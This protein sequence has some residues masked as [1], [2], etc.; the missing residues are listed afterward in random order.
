MYPILGKIGPLTIYSFGVMMA[1]GFYLGT[2]MAVREYERRGGDGD[3]LWSVLLWT[4]LA[5]VASARVLSIFNDIPGFFADPL[6]AFSG[7]G[8]VWYGGF[9]GG[10]VTAWF[11]T[12]RHKMA[13]SV[14]AECASLGL[15]LGQAIGRL[16]CHVA[17]DGDWGVPT[18]LPWGL[19][20][21][22]AIVGWPHPEGVY[23]H[24]T[25]LY[26]F[27]A[28]ML[29]FAVLMKVRH[30]NPPVGTM[31]GIYLVGNAFFRFVVEFWRINPKWI[32]GLTQAQLIAVG[33]FVA[34]VVLLARARGAAGGAARVAR[35]AAL[36]VALV[37]TVVGAGGCNP[38]DRGIAID[39]PAPGFVLATSDGA[40][41]KLDGWRG[42][43]VL[44]N[45]WAT[46][47]PPCVA[48]WPLLNAVQTR[49]ADRGLVV[50]AVAGDEN[51]EDVRAFLAEN[52][53]QF[54]VLLDPD[55]AVGTRYGITGYPETF[56][57]D[58][59]GVVRGKYIGPVPAEGDQP[60]AEFTELVERLVAS[61]P[62]NL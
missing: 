29:V 53:A 52:P 47:C 23:V 49:F 46:W 62:P 12:R 39:Q 25:P 32:F 56:L 16:G 8:F 41:R 30:R 59:E 34:G 33:L 19:A 27:A 57:I 42:Q 24:P 15:A 51:A 9:L 13:F 26:E 31:F 38:A 6:V 54:P 50:V 58:R 18:T 28:Y 60:A 55:G 35:S 45:L 2:T 10:T 5:G 4:F 20:Y 3:R 43:V 22:N 17:G 40:V 14:V 7:S 21:T 37:A 48:E 44:L 11:L 61:Q 36:A 1:I